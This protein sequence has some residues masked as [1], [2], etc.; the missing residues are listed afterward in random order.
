MPTGWRPGR[1]CS[2]ADAIV[3]K[4][5]HPGCPRIVAVPRP[6]GGATGV[7][8][9]PDAEADYPSPL[10]DYLR[11]ISSYPSSQAMQAEASRFG[12]QRCRGRLILRVKLCCR[13]LADAGICKQELNSRQARDR[14]AYAQLLTG[15]SSDWRAGLRTRALLE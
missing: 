3:G 5:K 6:P 1:C 2:A 11:A 15:G 4:A 10:A 7:P 12:T 9:C 14:Q 8:V 13:S